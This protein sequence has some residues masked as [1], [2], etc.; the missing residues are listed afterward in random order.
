MKLDK[1]TADRIAADLQKH[2]DLFGGAYGATVKA[3]PLR[4]NPNELR[5]SVTVE[6]VL[7]GGRTRQQELYDAYRATN[8]LPVIGTEVVMGGKTLTIAGMTNAGKV[9]LNGSNGK[10]YTA[11]APAVKAAAVRMEV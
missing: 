1:A 7:E 3:G 9:I 11:S 2:L 6:G 5:F 10:S 8:G 4:Y